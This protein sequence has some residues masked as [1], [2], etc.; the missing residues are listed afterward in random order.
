[1]SS[2]IPTPLTRRRGAFEFAG[3]WRDHVRALPETGMGYIVVSVALRDGRTFD[4]V[5]ISDTGYVDRVRGL[6]DI[7]FIEDDIVKIIA[8]HRKWDWKEAP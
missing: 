5:L 3:K 7:P 8:T 6:P 1:M 4:Q 2:P